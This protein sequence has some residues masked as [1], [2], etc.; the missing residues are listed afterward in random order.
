VIPHV[1]VAEGAPQP[2]LD[3]AI[4]QRLM[5]I[6]PSY[7]VEAVRA[8][9]IDSCPRPRPP[10]RHRLDGLGGEHPALSPEPQTLLMVSAETDDGRPD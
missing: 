1:H 6:F 8:F 3:H 10:E 2:V 7:V 9:D 5:P 4:D